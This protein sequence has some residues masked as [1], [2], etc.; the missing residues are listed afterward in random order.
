M[1]VLQKENGFS[2]IEVVASIVI[3]TIILLTF[4]QLFIQSNKTAA[5]N[6]EK[7]VLI[8]LADGQL[9]R[10]QA[11]SFSN[12]TELRGYISSTNNIP[13]QLNNKEYMVKIEE[14]NYKVNGNQKQ[15][16]SDYN[17][18]HL[19][20]SVSINNSKSVAEGYVKIK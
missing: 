6:N 12:I 15:S 7:L 13:I 11:L 4:S 17:L 14:T 5:Y 19:S 1:N 2:L 16:F 3:I 8:N 20:V 9:E 10:I 18:V